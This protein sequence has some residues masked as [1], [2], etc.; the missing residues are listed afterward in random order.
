MIALLTL[1]TWHWQLRQMNTTYGETPVDSTVCCMSAFP[2]WC[3]RTSTPSSTFG[4]KWNANHEPGC[5]G[6]HQWP[7]SQI[8]VLEQIV[9]GTRGTKSSDATPSPSF[10]LAY[11]LFA[12]ISLCLSHSFLNMSDHNQMKFSLLFSTQT[13]PEPSEST[14]PR[15]ICREFSFTVK[16]SMWNKI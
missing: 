8:T 5:I 2:A 6:Q 7:T 10:A 16:I 13:V 11:S 14:E 15:S 3:G 4:M 1:I 12:Y 9:P